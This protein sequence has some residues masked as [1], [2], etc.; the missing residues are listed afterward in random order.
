MSTAAVIWVSPENEQYC[1]TK[2]QM[3][4]G[5]GS[6]LDETAGHGMNSQ[7]ADEG[8]GAPGKMQHKADRGAKRQEVQPG[9]ARS[10]C[11]LVTPRRWLGRCFGDGVRA[12]QFSLLD[13]GVHTM[14][15]AARIQ[16]G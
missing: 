3:E 7:E 1:R 9:R 6:P 10:A 13:L 15:R 11:R 5:D 2:T 14:G 8:S 16:R 4:I 12:R